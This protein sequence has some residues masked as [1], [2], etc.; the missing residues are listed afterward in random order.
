MKHFHFNH[1]GGVLEFLVED[2]VDL[3]IMETVYLNQEVKKVLKILVKFD[4]VKLLLAADAKEVFFAFKMDIDQC[5][6]TNPSDEEIGQLIEGLLIKKINP[7]K[8]PYP[9]E[10][11]IVLPERKKGAYRVIEWKNLIS[12]HKNREQTL[13]FETQQKYFNHLMSY[14]DLKEKFLK[15]NIFFE[16]RKGCTAN[17]NHI[18]SIT[19]IHNNYY[20]CKL[21]DGRILEINANDRTRL[22]KFLEKKR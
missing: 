9:F 12:F 17:I 6:T 11:K 21:S 15:K 5:Y 7:L 3:V 20:H 2:M 10:G 18:E 13:I 8:Q 4:G 19:Y 16:L 14:E 1:L 22:L